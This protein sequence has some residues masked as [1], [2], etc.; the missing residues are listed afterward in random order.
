MERWLRVLVLSGTCALA[1]GCTS[2]HLP[3]LRLPFMTAQPVPESPPTEEP[4]ASPSVVASDTRGA[5]PARVIEPRVKRTVVR[6]VKIEAEDFEVGPYVGAMSLE[7]FGTNPAY[8]MRLSYHISEDLF[9]EIDVGRSKGATTSYE[10]LTGDDLFPG[11]GRQVTYYDLG[12]YY[13]LLPGEVFLGKGRALNSALYVGGT[14]G[15]LRMGGQNHFTAGLGVG[16]RVM[17]NDWLSLRADFRNRLM[18]SPIPGL[19]RASRNP[20]MVVGFTVFF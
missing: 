13:N 2:L 18:R 14:V 11:S 5:V 17:V 19:G 7:E 3:S 20:E 16:Y 1:A 9:A 12:G 10:R 8:G 15:A 4:T 6:Q